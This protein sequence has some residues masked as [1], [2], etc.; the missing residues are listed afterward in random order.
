MCCPGC[1]AVAT[2]IVAGGLDNYYQFRDSTADTPSDVPADSSEKEYDLYDLEEIQKDFVVN[3][4]E[5]PNHKEATL[6]VE[7]ISCAACVW[8]I[9]HHLLKLDGVDQ[10]SVNL[11]NHKAHVV[12]HPDKLKLSQ[13]L[14]A[15]KYIGYKGSPYHPDDEDKLRTQENRKALRRIG[16]AG[17]GMMQVMMYAIALYAGAMHGIDETHQQFIRWISLLVA[18]P[19]V[20]YSA[21]IFFI[22]AW[23]DLKTFS[24]SSKHLTMDV[25]VSL[26][27]GGAY[28]A[29]C[30][31]TIQNNG[32]VYFDS[33]SMFTFFLLLG[34][35]LEMRA[36]HVTG[37]ASASLNRLLPTA[38]HKI[39]NGEIQ[40]VPAK[41][42][43]PGDNIIIEPGETIAADCVIIE[44][45]SNVDESALTGEFLPVKKS[46][47]DR[48]VAGTINVESPLTA[49]V[50][51]IGNATKVSAIIRLLDRAQ[52]EKPTIAR[53]ADR[54]ASYFVAGV[55]MSAFLV[56]CVWTWLEPT[57]AFWITLS[58]LVVTCPCALSLAT[59]TALTAATGSLRKIGFFITR[60]RVLEGLPQITHVVFDKT[61]TLTEGQMALTEITPCDGFN[62]QDCL[63]LAAALEQ[64]SQHPIAKAF[65]G[66]S[67]NSNTNQIRAHHIKV[68]PGFGVE[69]IINNVKVRIGQAKY[70]CEQPNLTAPCED[71][72]WILLSVAQKP[73]CWFQLSDRLRPQAVSAIASLKKQGLELELLSGDISNQVEKIAEQLGINKFSAGMTPDQKLEHIKQLQQQGAKVLMVGDGI[74]DVPVIAVADLSVAMGSATDL[75]KTNADAV[76]VSGNLLQ[77]PQA[78]EQSR[79][80][81]NIITQNISWA[82]LY[83]LTVLPLAA[84]GFIPPYMAAIGMSLSSLLVVGNASRL[85]RAKIARNKSAYN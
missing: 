70:A 18:T 82:L 72:Q 65:V 52:A 7:G 80:T 36:R 33:V 3:S 25:P 9:E 21:Q 66:T 79:K 20:F 6:L 64:H 8:L 1:Q 56:A 67:T 32:E 4:S 5:Q 78:I 17:I 47:G 27:I 14:K 35:Y 2:A 30:W 71:G 60:G 13:L 81:K 51:H 15:L 77:L 40:L 26:A 38:A 44:G 75:A 42:L 59:P 24:A 57:Q 76:L 54:V 16:I 22:N 83:N 62:Q 49:Q 61:G 12:W 23:R 28:L 68:L 48:I 41:Q 39:I 85:S 45:E 46:S 43:N 74:N 34:R 63:D 84:F 53:I 31:A 11:S 73:A 58:V 37:Q 50:E 29:S 69:G 19:V 55:L 10:I